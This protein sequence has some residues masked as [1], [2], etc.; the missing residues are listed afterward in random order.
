M[1]LTRNESHVPCLVGCLLHAVVIQ[2]GQTG[3]IPDRRFQAGFLD[4]MILMIQQQSKNHQNTLS[5]KD[6]KTSTTQNGTYGTI[7]SNIH[8]VIAI[9]VFIPLC[10]Q[11]APRNRQPQRGSLVT[12]VTCRNS[13]VKRVAVRFPRCLL[14]Y[15]AQ[16]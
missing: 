12:W 7:L 3:S 13:L 16:L 5:Y 8:I 2:T 14:L 15:K 1:K 9:P 11:V 4:P 10:S 6:K